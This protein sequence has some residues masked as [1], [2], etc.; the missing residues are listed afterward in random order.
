[1]SE[2]QLTSK[3]EAVLR[4]QVFDDS[5]PGAVLHDFQLVLDHIGEKGVKAGGKYNLLPIE[6]IVALDPLLSRPLNLPLERPQLRSHPYLQGLHLLLRAS[7]LGRV[8]GKGDKARLVIDQTVLRSWNDL[9]PTERYFSLLEAWLL[10]A[11]P[12]M[13]GMDREWSDCLLD[14][15]DFS[16]RYLAEAK[17]SAQVRRRLRSL[18]ERRYDELYNLA[19]ADLFGLAAT[20]LQGGSIEDRFQLEVTVTPFGEA[21]LLLLGKELQEEEED[22]DIQYQVVADQEVA[23]EDE[24][25]E[26]DE[27]EDEEEYDLRPLLQP[28]FPAYQKSLALAANPPEREGVYVFKVSLGRDVWRRIALSHN[29]TLHDLLLAILRSIKFDYDH[30]YEFTFRDSLGRTVKANHPS[31]E[32][33]YSA[34]TVELGSLPLQPGESMPLVYD[35]GD[36]WRFDVKLEGIEPIGS[37]KRLPK[38]LESHGKAPKQY[39]DWD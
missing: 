30:L 37:I 28:Y 22:R 36:D 18:F 10:I 21:L 15:W 34:D 31:C 20:D 6:S 13:V 2:I 26:G 33:G 7:T 19:L 24:E 16:L 39:P 12:A 14:E 4:S 23:F 38:V 11:Q 27:E 5:H 3:Q 9:N 32:D 8:E 29:H 25:E 35:F 17:N 1:M